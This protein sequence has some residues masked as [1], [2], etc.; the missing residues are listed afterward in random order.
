MP[1]PVHFQS[2]NSLTCNGDI[3]NGILLVFIGGD[4][5]QTFSVEMDIFLCL[6]LEIR[7][8][9]LFQIRYFITLH[10]IELG[11]GKP[12]QYRN[13]EIFLLLINS[14]GNFSFSFANSYRKVSHTVNTIKTISMSFVVKIGQD[15]KNAKLVRFTLPWSL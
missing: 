3:L 13:I 11:E 1:F 9:L 8:G 6:C 4:N 10:N 7:P 14:T 15:L 2:I 12:N 5:S